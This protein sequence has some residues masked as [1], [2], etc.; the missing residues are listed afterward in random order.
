MAEA[1]PATR[2][3]R[4]N[5]APLRPERDHV[6]YWMVAARRVRS[7]FALD[8]AVELSREL[9]KPLLVFEA[10]RCGYRWANDRLHAFVLQ[11]MADNAAR[12]A[13]KGVAYL[14]YVEP[15]PDH[16]KGLLAA[17][18]ARA[19][20]VVTDDWPCFFVPRMVETA[21]RML[22][23]RLEA[24]DGNGMLPLAAQG[25]AFGRAFDLRR[26]LQKH[27]PD[28]LGRAPRKDSL[29]PLHDMPRAVIPRAVTSRWKPASTAQLAA[30]AAALAALPIDHTVA[31]SRRLHGGSTTAHAQLS[32]FLRDGFSRYAVERSHPDADAQSGLS[33]WLHFGHI[34]VHE[35][36][37]AVTHH[38]DWS[39]ARISSAVTGS[40]TGW[41]GGSANLESFLDELITW[42]ELGF[43]MCHHAPR[44]YDR[45]E[46]LPAWARAS[47]ELHESDPRPQLY[48]IDE[49]ADG[50]TDDP[51]WNAAQNELRRDGRMQN[52]LRMLWGKRVLEWTPTARDAAAVLVE[53]N[54]RFAID[55]RDPNSYS[56]IFWC[57]GRYDRPW[58]PE[59]PVFG[60]IRYMSSAN[61]RR[62]LKLTRYLACHGGAEAPMLPGFA[63]T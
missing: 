58:A 42:R 40:N 9:G 53:L 30:S 56:G 39:A 54:N 7:N 2:L 63:D 47:L 20:A 46:S 16:G 48:T 55:G 22:D 44:D 35:V 26:F 8:R 45:Y 14:P 60:V 12:C 62:K 29:S 5:S 41:W 51:L 43:G 23:V 15:E 17:L 4:V 49:L 50:R 25:R 10:L 33:P 59:R 57:L 36:F 19:C 52:Y 32:R 11:G 37:D 3:R 6:L 38:D 21:G 13:A 31:P 28:H 1:V 34:G 27:L 24:V 61:T 18:A